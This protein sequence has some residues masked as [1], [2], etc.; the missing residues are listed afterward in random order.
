MF[1]KP[2][3][4]YLTLIQIFQENYERIESK[5]NPESKRNFSI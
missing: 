5:G 4:N 1:L 2:V 3:I